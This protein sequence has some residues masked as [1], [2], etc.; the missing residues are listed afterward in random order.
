MPY[1]RGSA[2]ENSVGIVGLGKVGKS[3]AYNFIKRGFRVYA[4]THKPLSVDSKNRLSGIEVV[5]TEEIP[6]HTKIVFLAVEDHKIEE[7]FYEMKDG[8]TGGHLVIVLSGAFDIKKLMVEGP[9]IV[10]AHP[11][12]A[13]KEDEFSDIGNTIF[14]IEGTYGVD[15]L[16]EVI[17]CLNCR[18]I[19]FKGD[20]RLYH[21][22]LVFVS[23]FIFSLYK[24]GE[25]MLTEAGFTDENTIKEILITLMK[26]AV[27]NI[28]KADIFGLTGPVERNDTE[29]V[30]SHLEA[31]KNEDTRLLYA[32]LSLKLLDIAK[33]KYPCNNYREIEAILR[34]AM[35]K[36]E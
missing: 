23:N 29:T 11:V 22:S 27:E 6:T 13:F 34:G 28:E 21:A 7:A 3:L 14:V 30:L 20:F 2:L 18:Y 12:R 35:W 17:E 33:K 1:S 4:S 24:E 8:L 16:K 25:E 32:L 9:C 26:N 31:I 15:L 36:K 10:R 19:E 5:S